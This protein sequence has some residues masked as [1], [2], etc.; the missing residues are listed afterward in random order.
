MDL[1]QYDPDKVE[2]IHEWYQE[3]WE[4]AEPYDLAGIFDARLEEYD[5]HT[6]YLRMLYAQYSPELVADEDARA[7][8][9]TLQLADF[10]RIGSQRAL[11]ILEKWHGAILADGVGL[12]KTIIA[13]DII[14][15]YT[16]ERGLRVLIVCPAALREMWERFL[17][18]HNLPGKVLS[19][20]QLGRDKRLV[21][22][23]ET[24]HL[25][26]PPEQFRL[27]V[28]DEAHAL[29]S[30]DTLAYGAMKSLLAQSPKADLLLLTATPVNNSL[31]DLYHEIMLFAKTDNRFEGI[32]VPNLRER[33]KVATRIDPDDIDPSHLFDVLDAISV[34]RTRRFIKEHFQGA[35]IDGKV[36]SFPQVRTT[37]EHYDLDAVVPG[38][39]EDVAKAIE[40]LKMARYR[41]Q[42]YAI[43]PT[44][45]R[46]R[47]EALAG[48]LQSQMLKRFE[49]SAFAFHKTVEAMIASHDAALRLI[50]EQGLV[51]LRAIEASRLLDEDTVDSLMDD[52]DIAES[53][54]F[55]V[56]KLCRDLRADI[57]VLRELERKVAALNMQD[58]PKLQ[59]LLEIIRSEAENPDPD[60]R[61]TLVFTSYVDTVEYIRAYLAQKALGDPVIERVVERS[62]YVLGNQK[63]DVETRAEYAAGF[64]PKSMRPGEGA[65]DKYDLL[66]TTDVLSEG[67]NLQQ[68]GRIVN[69]DLPWNP[70][71]IV[72]RDGRIDRIGSPHV[73]VFVHCFMPD[74]QLDA[75]LK[76]EER[77][78][79]KIAQAN[80][81]I[82]VEGVIVPGIATREQNF[83]DSEAVV[84][85]RS[86]QIRRLADGDGDVLA[87]LDRDD[88]YSGEQFREELRSAL[89]SDAGGDLEKLPWGIGSGHDQGQGPAVV[90]L[91][92][93]GRRH[94]FRLVNLADHAGTISPDLLEALKR[95]RCHP[96]GQRV[97]PEDLRAVVYDAWER[98]K[99]S[100]H[101]QLQEQRDPANRQGPLPK[102]Q[103][104]A[105]DL[106][107]RANNEQAADAA[108][109]LASRW[110]TDVERDL[111]RILRNPDHSETQRVADLAE[112]VQKRGLK[113]QAPEEVPD[114]RAGDI[115]LI[116][117][118]LVVPKEGMRNDGI[119]G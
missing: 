94:F 83:A 68:C 82:G 31:W 97:Y 81:G 8:F 48:L 11:R 25:G 79:R 47:Q 85:E 35:T 75:L 44:E 112:Y 6:I 91:V 72:Q 53:D 50:E 90:F 39:F 52:G 105:I 107:L 19:Y 100:L 71:R 95:A 55:D 28:A 115:K 10:Q 9:G 7:I 34:R 29:R 41:P 12:G 67:Q 45:A 38:L 84:E 103:R 106:L 5:P 54:G 111:R 2:R 24:D 104:E 117:Y 33:I 64:A 109:A 101:A 56:K 27:V 93:A 66:V 51:P 42:A 17:Q 114:V 62:E 16:V 30:Q 108:E 20:A 78:Q 13:G 18:H 37:A 57:L 74:V 15:T 65:E 116:C 4:N 87:E 73:E 40:D 22:D 26:L 3:L 61:K 43:E 60:K 119:T 58:D 76:L 77:L 113:P 110:P 102:V 69:F 46:F 23:G 86:E 49:S 70:M 99:H 63:T 21:E 14:R 92:R 80:A 59:N 98:V 96:A 1:G 89:L 118:Q 36:I 32:G 88:A